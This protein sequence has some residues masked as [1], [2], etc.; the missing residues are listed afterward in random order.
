[1]KSSTMNRIN[2]TRILFPVS[3]FFMVSSIAFAVSNYEGYMEN[4]CCNNGPYALH[5]PKSLKVL[6]SLGKLKSERIIRVDNVMGTEDRELI[7]KGLRLII[8]TVKD[9][10]DYSIARVNITGSS[11]AIVSDFRVGDTVESIRKRLSVKTV[12]GGKWLEV[13]GDTDE[14]R[15]RISDGKVVEIEYMC[16]TG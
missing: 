3:L 8:I 4:I 7:Y 16:Y 5:L 12:K 1:M 6:R 15:F 11:W 9:K 13:G 2:F 10:K 14:L